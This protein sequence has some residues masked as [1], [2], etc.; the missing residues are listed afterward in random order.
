MFRE[1]TGLRLGFECLRKKADHY[2]EYHLIACK[3]QY[4]KTND[5]IEFAYT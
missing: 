2:L 4:I 3:L 5:I 1:F